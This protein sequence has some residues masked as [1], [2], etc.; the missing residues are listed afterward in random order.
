MPFL[1]GTPAKQS[2]PHRQG[3]LDGVPPTRVQQQQPRMRGWVRT[4]KKMGSYNNVPHMAWHEKSPLVEVG[5]RHAAQAGTVGQKPPEHHI[6]HRADRQTCIRAPSPKKKI[7]GWHTCSLG[8]H[9]PPTQSKPGAKAQASPNNGPG[10]T[11]QSLAA[12]KNDGTKINPY[13]KNMKRRKSNF[14]K[15]Q[16]R[17]RPAGQGEKMRQTCAKCDEKAYHS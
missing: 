1:G 7:P 11:L 14:L 2:N 10:P 9:V 4:K 16:R 13:Q 12:I 5:K 15:R 3:S 17:G 8:R 6:K